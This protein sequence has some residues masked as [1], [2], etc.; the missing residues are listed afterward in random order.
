MAWTTW[1][2]ERR[3]AGRSFEKLKKKKSNWNWERPGRD[4]RERELEER[5][6]EICK[7]YFPRSWTSLGLRLKRQ[8]RDWRTVLNWRILLWTLESQWPLIVD[9]LR[10]AKMRVK[11]SGGLVEKSASVLN[12]I[13]F[14]QTIRTH[15]SVSETSCTFYL[16]FFI[17]FYLKSSLCVWILSESDLSQDIHAW[18]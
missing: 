6:R 4:S 17:S 7:F 3:R 1:E 16:Y 11:T 8:R 18:I 10:N 13:R 5:E 15:N 12:N 9:N 14:F 2:R